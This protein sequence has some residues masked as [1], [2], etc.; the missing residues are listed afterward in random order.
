MF[1]CS[2]E[3]V[4]DKTGLSCK[5]S[6]TENGRTRVRGKYQ[7]QRVSTTWIHGLHEFM[8]TRFGMR[9]RHSGDTD[10]TREPI[11]LKKGDLWGCWMERTGDGGKRQPWRWSRAWFY[12]RRLFGSACQGL[13]FWLFKLLSSAHTRSQVAAWDLVTVKLFLSIGFSK[14]S[15]WTTTFAKYWASRSAPVSRIRSCHS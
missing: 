1:H 13:V 12:P 11:D 14:L 10:R 3:C 8:N 6:T 4:N 5:L 7:I 15:D 9:Y 2:L